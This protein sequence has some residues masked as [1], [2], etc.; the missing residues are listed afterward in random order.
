MQLV[1]GII[2]RFVFLHSLTFIFPPMRGDWTRF[3]FTLKLR[4]LSYCLAT[5]HSM[6]I[7]SPKVACGIIQK[8]YNNYSK[9]RIKAQRLNVALL[10]PHFLATCLVHLSLQNSSNLTILG[11]QKTLRCFTL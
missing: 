7:F 9:N 5:M 10:T 8:L 6:F 11:E 3:N 2:P 4:L 1:C